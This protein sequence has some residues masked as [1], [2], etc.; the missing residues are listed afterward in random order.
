[1]VCHLEMAPFTTQGSHPLSGAWGLCLIK[2]RA[3]L[4]EA[5]ISSRTGNF[6]AVAGLSCFIR[7]IN[8]VDLHSRV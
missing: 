1:M 6:L 2:A 5:G 8:I 3:K 7:C 4:A